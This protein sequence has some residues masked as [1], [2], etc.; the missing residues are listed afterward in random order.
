ME[1]WNCIDVI[2]PLGAD[3]RAAI[4]RSLG[5]DYAVMAMNL[6]GD[7]NIGSMIR[8]A[9]LMGARSFFLTGRRKYDRR[10]AVGTNHYIDVQ[11]V[12]GVYNVLIDTR[13]NVACTC[14]ECKYVDSEALLKFLLEYGGTPCFVEQDL[15]AVCVTDPVWKRTVDRPVFIFGNEHSGV[16][17][18]TIVFIK[19]HIPKTIVLQIPQVGVLRSLNVSVACNVVLWEFMRARL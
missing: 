13:H 18:E 16:S 17:R 8:T 4:H 10:Y 14:G 3:V 7:N 6:N 1:E 5:A 12:P 15:G 11:F 2:K 19:E 9:A